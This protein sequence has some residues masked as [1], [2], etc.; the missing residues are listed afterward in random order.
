[1]TDWNSTL[2]SIEGPIFERYAAGLKTRAV[3]EPG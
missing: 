2:T 3:R 1:M